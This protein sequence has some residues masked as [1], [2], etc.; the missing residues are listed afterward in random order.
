VIGGR[1]DN[2]LPGQFGLRQPEGLPEQIPCL[3]G[4]ASCTEFLSWKRRP[5]EEQHLMS[6]LRQQVGSRGTCRAGTHD[7]DI[8]S[9]WDR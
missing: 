3:L 5:V 1:S 4:Q 2:P 6:V 8:S 7:D 9:G